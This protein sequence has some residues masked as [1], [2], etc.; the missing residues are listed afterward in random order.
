M[1]QPSTLREP[2]VYMDYHATTPMDPRV[3]DTMLPYFT[4]KFGNASSRSHQFGWD[5]EAAVEGARAQVA[6]LIGAAPR[7]I[8]FTSGATE[9]D[10]LAIQGV[11]EALRNQGNH[12][13]T[14]TIEHRA[15]LDTCKM[16]EAR[17]YQITR[18]PVQP[19][20]RVDPAQ[21]RDAITGAT[22]L[23]SIMAANNEIGSLQPLAEIGSICRERG[24][25]FH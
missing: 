23:V 21:A 8:I 9:S 24:V 7:E 6:A 5:A 20:G 1:L 15:V 22:I 19:D 17:G 10:N 2:P 25:L 3:L 13:I 4:G 16:L 18:L 14:S 11:A 12:I